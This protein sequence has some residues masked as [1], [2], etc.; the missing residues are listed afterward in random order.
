VTGLKP[1]HGLRRSTRWPATRGRPEGR[2][3]HGL[4]AQSRRQ[5]ATRRNGARAVRARGAVTSRCSRTRQHG[6]A[7]NGDAVRAGQWQGVASEHRRGPG[8]APGRQR[9]GGANPSGGS[10]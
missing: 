3:G 9:G 5:P 6:D 8:V 2:L 10:M 1:A 7:L 4:A